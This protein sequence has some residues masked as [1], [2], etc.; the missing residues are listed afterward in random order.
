MSVNWKCSDCEAFKAI[1]ELGDEDEAVQ[2][3]R[4]LR[5]SLIY[6][7]LATGFPSK[8]PWE[9]TEGNVD[10]VFLRLSSLEKIGGAYRVRHSTQE[11]IPFTYDEVRSMIGLRV[12]AGNKSH[13]EWLRHLWTIHKDNA[14]H[15]IK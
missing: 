10:E 2:E 4:W 9:I 15:Q 5:D 11:D 1:K 6:A 12:N 3:F 14:K 8:S 7:L 13:T